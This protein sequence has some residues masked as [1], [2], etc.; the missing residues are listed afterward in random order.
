MRRNLHHPPFARH[1]HLSKDNKVIYVSK[2]HTHENLLTHRLSSQSTHKNTHKH[3]NELPIKT[4]G[5]S[6][7]NGFSRR[8]SLPWVAQ[9][10]FDDYHHSLDA[11]GFPLPQG[12]LSSFRPYNSGMFVTIHSFTLQLLIVCQTR[13]SRPIRCDVWIV[14]RMRYP[15]NQPTDRPTD[16]H[17]QL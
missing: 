16:G 15:T 11:I 9:W 6:W 13:P 2:C 3:T 10:Q 17:S 12:S 14:K 4:I 8:L 5:T 1:S 7:S